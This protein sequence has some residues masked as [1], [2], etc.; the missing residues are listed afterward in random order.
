MALGVTIILGIIAAILIMLFLAASVRVIQPY[1][2][3]L[4]IF[5]GKY[6]RKLNTGVNLVI[7]MG[8]RVVRMD[9]RTQVLDVPRQEV[10]TKD[11]SPT[12]VDAIIYTKVVDPERA[13]FE[14]ADYRVAT[15]ALAQTTLRSVI[16]D[17]EL[18]EV[19]YSREKINARLR[20]TLD[21]A[22]D[23]WG[24]RIEA[25]E[26]REVDPVDRVKRAM[27]EQTSAE[28]ERRAAILKA[29]GQKRAAILEAEGLKRARI[30]A[31]EGVRQSKIVEAE[32]ER[33]AQ[34]LE[35]QGKAQALRILSL[36]AAPLDAKALSVLS[37]DALGR[38]G[39]GQAT[40]I[41]LP[42][43]VTRALQGVSRYLGDASEA[44]PAAPSDLKQLEAMVGMS[45]DVLGDIPSHEAIRKELDRLSR[46]LSR[47][48]E[49]ALQVA[50]GKAEAKAEADRA[51][52]DAERERTGAMR[53]KPKAPAEQGPA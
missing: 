46:E 27:E 28:R 52:K 38:L 22:T 32:G 29:D 8:T 36:G 10:I 14:V 40:K 50:E 53:T 21:S 44:P 26:I 16:G 43:E 20:D 47:D 49:A 3:A 25:V 23:A 35:T 2:Q 42:F 13:F 33:T 51:R 6:R 37:L 15:V 34:I 7:P 39:E 11:N 1:E 41:V 19:L 24:V 9:M 12:H 5:L 45:R 30:L 48:E 18:D 17:M 4:Y 31:A